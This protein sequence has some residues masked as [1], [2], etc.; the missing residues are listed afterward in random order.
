CYFNLGDFDNAIRQYNAFIDKF[1][2]NKEILPLV[3]QKLA[4]AYFKT[5]Q[6]DKA[7]ETLARLAEIED[8]AFKD[9]ALVLEARYYER[10]GEDAKALEKYKELSTEFPAS[11]WSAE[12]ASKIAA[13]EAKKGGEKT[14]GGDTA[15]KAA[16]PDKP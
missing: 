7:L 6:N 12:A 16:S 14:A 11:P 10:A 13:A 15:P 3:Y 8:G 4:A 2:S 9:T 5:K 1:S